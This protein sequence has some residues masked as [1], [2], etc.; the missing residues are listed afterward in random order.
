MRFDYAFPPKLT[1]L[2]R[3]LSHNQREDTTHNCR[4]AKC[5]TVWNPFTAPGQ[6]RDL[7]QSTH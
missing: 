3:A 2:V 4:Y 1:S 5:G 7:S 6:I